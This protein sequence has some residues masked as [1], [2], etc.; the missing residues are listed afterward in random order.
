MKEI[1]AAFLIRT[2]ATV[3]IFGLASCATK[4]KPMFN[5]PE[6][7]KFKF[8][9]LEMAKKEAGSAN[10]PLFVFAHASWC[11]TCKQMEKEVLIDKQLGNTFNTA[12]LNV[13]IDIDSPDGR[14]LT[15]LYPI[16]G[17]PTLLFFT[18][19]GD[20]AKKIVGFTTTDELLAT[21]RELKN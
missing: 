16:Q 1:K 3:S 4:S 5:S 9:S 7:I 8:I 6:G 11:P 10:K 14:L 13:A 18:S 21:A 15:K 12:F 17:T 2:I 19:R 20:M